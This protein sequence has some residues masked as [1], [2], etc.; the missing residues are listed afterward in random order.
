L[1]C[2]NGADL[3][4]RARSA[5]RSIEITPMTEAKNTARKSDPSKPEGWVRRNGR[6][7]FFWIGVLATLFGAWEGIDHVRALLDQRAQEALA[8]TPL[9]DSSQVLHVSGQDPVAQNSLV[10]DRIEVSG[11]VHTVPDG[12]IWLAN[13][14]VLSEGATLRTSR[15]SIIAKAVTGGRID[16]SGA[17]AAGVGDTPTRGGEIA[18]FATAVSNVEL[19]VRG[20]DGAPGAPGPPGPDGREG[21]CQGFGGY[22]GAD[23]GRNGQD[24]HPGGDGAPGGH[25]RVAAATIAP[26]PQPADYRGGRGGSGGPGGRGGRGGTGCVGLGGSQPSQPSGHDGNPGADNKAL[27]DSGGY[28]FTP[29]EYSALLGVVGKSTDPKLVLDKA[30]HSLWHPRMTSPANST[31][32]ADAPKSRS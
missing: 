11:G 30:E 26:A 24:G 1:V 16:A 3:Q 20:G 2:E 5:T 7:A 31:V 6:R 21:S 25:I 14:V 9:V 15:I 32:G 13:T 10:A 4:A 28:D 19:V 17:S 23:P 29:T 22:R 8:K 12:S 27:G 18:I